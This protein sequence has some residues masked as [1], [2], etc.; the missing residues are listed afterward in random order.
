M[1]EAVAEA[2]GAYAI[3]C[4]EV[5]YMEIMRRATWASLERGCSEDAMSSWACSRLPLDCMHPFPPPPPGLNIREL[6]ADCG[7]L[8]L[9]LALYN[10]EIGTR[11]SKTTSCTALH[12][13]IVHHSEHY[14]ALARELAGVAPCP[15]SSL[16]A[17]SRKRNT[18]HRTARSNAKCNSAIYYYLVC[19]FSVAAFDAMNKYISTL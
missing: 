14:R 3:G 2:G 8:S 4:T 19:R 9:W 10:L 6:L 5:I 11:Q 17:K 7:H 13:T 18:V 1:A 16:A 15:Q 12:R